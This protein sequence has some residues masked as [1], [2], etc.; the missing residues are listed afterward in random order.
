MPVIEIFPWTVQS[1][2]SILR[3]PKTWVDYWRKIGF[4]LNPGLPSAF[5]FIIV[6]LW[7]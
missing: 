6:L 3:L 5:Q 4:I 2:N 7:L 1:M